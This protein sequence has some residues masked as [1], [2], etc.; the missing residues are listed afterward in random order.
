MSRCPKTYTYCDSTRT[1][2]EPLCTNKNN[3]INSP[4]ALF[5][6]QPHSTPP[7]PLACGVGPKPTFVGG[8]RC[9]EASPERP[10][11]TKRSI[12]KK[13]CLYSTIKLS[14]A[15]AIWKFVFCILLPEDMPQR[16]VFRIAHT[17]RS[18]ITLIVAPSTSKQNAAFDTVSIVPSTSIAWTTLPTTITTASAVCPMR[19][20]RNC[21]RNRRR[22]VAN[23]AVAKTAHM[24]VTPQ[25]ENGVGDAKRRASTT[26]GGLVIQSAATCVVTAMTKT[27]PITRCTRRAR[28]ASR[29]GKYP[30]ASKG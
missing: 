14:L 28:C 8:D 6:T 22:S 29:P 7:S 27:I 5:F 21:R 24:A 2:P 25:T 18:A 12:S 1:S 20:V 17:R 9:S 11:D 23:I 15:S 13:E 30:P 16:C 10:F 19:H 4:S 3:K 26:S